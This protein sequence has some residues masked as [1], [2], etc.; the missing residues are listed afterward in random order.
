M[1]KNFT[2]ENPPQLD[3]TKI[4]KGFVGERAN[5]DSEAE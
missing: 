4:V 5:N 3:N 1:I 2:I